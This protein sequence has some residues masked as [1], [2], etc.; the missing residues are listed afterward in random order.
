LF[1]VLQRLGGTV[2]IALLA[3]YFQLREHFYIEN[4]LA[5]YGISPS[6]QMSTNS[7]ISSLPL[8]VLSQL[9]VAGVNGFRDTILVL[10]ILSFFGL[11]ASVLLRQI[12]GSTGN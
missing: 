11:M 1:N 10:V 7:I 8:S 12:S 5:K 9:S 3:T 4:V 2:G 6:G